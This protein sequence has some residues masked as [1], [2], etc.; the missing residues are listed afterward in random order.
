[1]K[2]NKIQEWDEELLDSLGDIFQTIKKY[3]YIY[4]PKEVECTKQN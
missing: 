1:M 4:K 3:K 2:K